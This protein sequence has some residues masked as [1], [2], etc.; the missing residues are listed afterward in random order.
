MKFLQELVN[1]L[2]VLRNTFLTKDQISNIFI[3]VKNIKK[4]I[5]F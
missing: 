5:E 3:C 4:F 1:K 2:K